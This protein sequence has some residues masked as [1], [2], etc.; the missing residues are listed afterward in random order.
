MVSLYKA[1]DPTERGFVQDADFY[2]QSGLYA[3]APLAKK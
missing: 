1:S 2:V 3:Q